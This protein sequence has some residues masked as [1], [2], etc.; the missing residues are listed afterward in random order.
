MIE[1][2]EIVIA[3]APTK[4][5]SPVVVEQVALSWISVKFAAQVA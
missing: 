3:P 2:V 4:G 1:R 5:T